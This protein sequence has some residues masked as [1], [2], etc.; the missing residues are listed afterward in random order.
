MQHPV[1]QLDQ[2]LRRSAGGSGAD[3]PPSAPKRRAGPRQTDRP[4]RKLT[5]EK[6][7]RRT[8]PRQSRRHD[9]AALTPD[10]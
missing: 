1:L 2:C 6:C 9:P 5:E 4:D 10:L 3:G 7:H 8:R